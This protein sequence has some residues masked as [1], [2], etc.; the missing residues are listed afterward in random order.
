MNMEQ[1]FKERMKAELERRLTYFRSQ[2]SG[3]MD[4]EEVRYVQG[5]EAEVESLLEFVNESNKQRR[6][7]KKEKAV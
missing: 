7:N 5:Q 2:T 4:Q 1:T 3:F 6:D